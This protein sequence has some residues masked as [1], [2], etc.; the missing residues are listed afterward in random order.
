[1]AKPCGDCH[2]PLEMHKRHISGAYR[3]SSFGCGCEVASVETHS[4]N[5]VTCRECNLGMAVTYCVNGH[6]SHNQGDCPVCGATAGFY[7]KP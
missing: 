7:A 2:H 6:E 5:R 1:M 3:C 4:H